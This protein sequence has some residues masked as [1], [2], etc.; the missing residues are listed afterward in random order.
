ML[1]Y[2]VLFEN[3]NHRN[4]ST[5]LDSLKALMDM[6]STEELQRPETGD[7]VNNHIH[8]SYSFSPY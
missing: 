4:T 3:L 5:R 2:G 7:D 8:T 6:I 1:D